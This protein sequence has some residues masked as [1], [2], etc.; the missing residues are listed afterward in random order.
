[1]RIKLIK[2]IDKDQGLQCSYCGSDEYRVYALVGEH[3]DIAYE[4]LMK[5][6]LC[7]DCFMTMECNDT[8]KIT[9]VIHVDVKEEVEYE[10]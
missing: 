1:M 3:E 7:A 4:E 8:M 9:E 5:E 6:A 10:D 2:F